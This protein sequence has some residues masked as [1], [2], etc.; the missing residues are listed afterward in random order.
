MIVHGDFVVPES[1]NNQI[2]RVLHVKLCK[3]M[4]IGLDEIKNVQ[5]TPVSKPNLVELKFKTTDENDNLIKFDDNSCETII[6]QL[7]D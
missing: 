5:Y 7:S 2:L 6:K 1:N 3:P 4:S